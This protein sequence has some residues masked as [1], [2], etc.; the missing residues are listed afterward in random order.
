MDNQQERL[1]GLLQAKCHE[2]PEGFRR[3]LPGVAELL[4][5]LPPR[6]SRLRS[7]FA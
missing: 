6:R 7:A 5:E 1:I 3:F 4:P 2:D